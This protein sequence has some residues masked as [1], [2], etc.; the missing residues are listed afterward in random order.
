MY[1]PPYVSLLSLPFSLSLSPFF[2]F[3]AFR[4]CCSYFSVCLSLPVLSLP[5]P[6]RFLYVFFLVYELLAGPR[7]YRRRRAPGS[8]SVPNVTP[9]TFINSP[10]LS[11]RPRRPRCPRAHSP[12]SVP[13]EAASIS[14]IPNRCY[15][16]CTIRYHTTATARTSRIWHT[17]RSAQHAAKP[18]F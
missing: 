10:R 5:P 18:L 14:A 11:K 7:R 8:S 15:Q 6:S 1:I 16:N 2:V 13:V 9:S 3:V 12:L 17:R 4:V